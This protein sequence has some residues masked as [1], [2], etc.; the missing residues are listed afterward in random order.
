[1]HYIDDDWKLHAPLICC[2]HINDSHDKETI[3]KLIAEKLKLFI[4]KETKIHTGVTDGGELAS[5]KFTAAELVKSNQY[6]RQVPLIITNFISFLII[7]RLNVDA[8]FVTS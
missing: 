3:G 4:S 6:C 7:L 1:M 2:S 5:V 8:V